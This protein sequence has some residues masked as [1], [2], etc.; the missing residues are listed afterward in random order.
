MTYISSVISDDNDL[1][2][3]YTVG[4]PGHGRNITCHVTMEHP[5]N[6]SPLI[7]AHLHNDI[8]C[9]LLADHALSGCRYLTYTQHLFQLSMKV[10]A[11]CN[12]HRRLAGTKWVAHVDVLPNINNWIHDLQCGVWNNHQTKARRGR[13]WLSCGELEN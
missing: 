12:L 7:T 11:L 2:I 3:H 1:F 10:N 6:G 13:L 5:K 4:H 9:Q 8:A